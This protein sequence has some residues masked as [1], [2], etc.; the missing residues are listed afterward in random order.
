MPSI[1]KI[2][3]H[4]AGSNPS[5]PVIKKVEQIPSPG[6]KMHIDF[7]EGEKLFKVAEPVQTLDVEGNDGSKPVAIVK[8]QPVLAGSFDDP[9]K[10]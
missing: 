1:Y 10:S 3:C 9:A 8:V 5:D 6:T 2:E 7:G 4:L